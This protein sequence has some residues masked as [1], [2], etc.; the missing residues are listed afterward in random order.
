MLWCVWRARERGVAADGPSVERSHQTAPC[1]VVGAGS[2]GVSVHYRR[3]A[4]SEQTYLPTP[5][6]KSSC[7]TVLPDRWLTR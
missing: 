5:G 6:S 1:G 2:A 3:S 7:A 4:T